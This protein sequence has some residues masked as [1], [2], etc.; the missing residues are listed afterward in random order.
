MH[1]TCETEMKKNVT[2]VLSKVEN[3]GESELIE[4]LNRC[5][6]W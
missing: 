4:M 5:R 6:T 1:T 3:M 2:D